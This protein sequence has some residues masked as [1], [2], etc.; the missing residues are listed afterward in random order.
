MPTTNSKKKPARKTTTDTAPRRGKAS[1]A[2]SAR[3][4]DGDPEVIDATRGFW[5]VH[6][7]TPSGRKGDT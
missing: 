6:E 3:D 7:Y 1:A 4:Y 5:R 2:A